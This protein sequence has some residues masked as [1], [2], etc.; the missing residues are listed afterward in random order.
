MLRSKFEMRKR[1]GTG[2]EFSQSQT[3]LDI[4][5]NKYVLKDGDVRRNTNRDYL[6]SVLLH[7][8]MKN[9]AVGN[10]LLAIKGLQKNVNWVLFSSEFD[11]LGPRL[12]LPVSEVLLFF[13]LNGDFRF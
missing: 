8:R 2:E 6:W 11:Y 1:V 12:R 5:I 4:P 3:I 10:P 13:H 7:N 9:C